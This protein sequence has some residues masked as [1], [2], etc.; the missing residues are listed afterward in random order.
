MNIVFVVLGLVILLTLTLKKWN[1]AIAALVSVVFIILFSGLPIMKTLTNAYLLGF[2]NFLKGTWLM[3]LL[4][5]I[6]SKIIDMTG[7][8]R[9][10]SNL[11]IG[12]LGIKRAIPA[13]IIAGALLTYGG[14]QAMVACFALYPITLAIFRKADLPRYLIPAVIGSGIFTWVNMLPGNPAIVN[15]IPTQ[16][17]GTTPMAAPA[18][19]IIAAVIAFVLTIL[20]FSYEVRKAKKKGIGF[21]ADEDTEKV[22]EQSDEL[23]KNGKLPNPWLALVPLISIAVTLNVFKADIAIALFVGIVLCVV[24]FWKNLR[25]I[26]E[27]ASDAANEAAKIAIISSAIVGIGSVIQAT[28]GFKQTIKVVIESGKSGANPLLIF[29]IATAILCGLCASAMGGLSTTLAA[30][31]KPFMQM[32]VNAA[33][34]HRIGVIASTSLDSLPHS[35]GIV[36]VLTIANVSYKDGYKHLFMVTVVITLFVALLSTLIAPLLYGL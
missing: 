35:G 20:Y 10:I 3:L 15:I 12:T 34:L 29:T 27:A 2:T 31:A 19:G 6:L 1:V 28:P 5:A 30:L 14:V 4:G 36:A 24:F 18:L 13:V 17:L 25:G 7:A 16:Y 23:I 11:I 8:A 21:V 9:S 33:V 22:L 32:G 26:R